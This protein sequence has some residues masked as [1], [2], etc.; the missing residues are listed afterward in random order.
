[1]EALEAATNPFGGVIPKPE[2]LPGELDVFSRRLDHSLTTWSEAGFKVVWLEL[3]M[4]RAGLVPTAVES[5]FSY[6]HT[7]EDYVML[8][9][10]LVENAF[11]P[12]FASH[13]VGAGGV[14]LN[15]DNE[16]LV[17][18]ERLGKP[19]GPRYYKL[20]GGTVREGE[21][22][23]EGVVREVLEETGV[24]TRFESLVCFRNLHGYRHGKSDIYF[25]CRLEPLS[26]RISMQAEEIEECLWMPVEKYF[27]AETVSTFNKLIV[28]ASLESTGL[29]S[30]R[31]DGY[32]D[33]SLYEAFLPE[34]VAGP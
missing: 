30:H 27:T 19:G 33:P 24:R 14:V 28:R 31:I 20:P 11:I 17:V 13:Y 23:S 22:L 32:R 12:P 25:V 15:A 10:R 34:N 29:A 21:H 5:G 1:M 2:A 7:G 18:H 8:T 6:H 4:A 26:H 3:P 16:L 9:L